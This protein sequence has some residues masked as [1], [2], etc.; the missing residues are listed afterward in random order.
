MVNRSRSAWRA[1]W[2]ASRAVRVAS[3]ATVLRRLARAARPTR[4]LTR[5]A[6][7][8]APPQISVII[9]ARNEEAR[10]EPCLTGLRGAP[11]VVEMIVVDDGSTDGTA[12]LARRLGARVVVAPPLPEGWAGKAW[13]LDQGLRAATG[14]WIVTLDAD[15]RPDPSLPAALVSRMVADRLDFATVAGRFDCPTTGARWLHPAMLTTLVYRYGPPGP[16]SN[17]AN[18]QCMA[19]PRAAWISAGGLQP[20]AGH[21]VE[22]VAL[23]RHLRQLGWSVSLLDG[24]ELLAVR[25]YESF[26]E[27]WSG[28][29]RSIALGGVESPPRQLTHLVALA[30]TQA[31][32]LLR[33]VMRRADP[34]DAVLVVCRLGTLAGTARAYQKRGPAYWL[35][36][37]ADGA[38][39][40]RLAW[41]VVKPS[42]EWRGRSYGPAR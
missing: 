34:L 12:E 22:D 17:L 35:S 2:W 29:G 15:A 39:V 42:R 33:I 16:H 40:A 11:G 9:P 20:V 6:I 41:S 24:A 3:T 37:L 8:V 23:A 5:P 13:A 25:M 30:A 27:T 18:G 19:A 36:P 31:F 1:S 10:L 26:A 14:E 28:W 4:P 21:V 7:S 38:A 32:P